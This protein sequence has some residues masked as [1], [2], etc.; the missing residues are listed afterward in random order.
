MAGLFISIWLLGAVISRDVVAWRQDSEVAELEVMGLIHDADLDHVTLPGGPAQP[1]EDAEPE[2]PS[3]F[4]HDPHPHP[5]VTAPGGPSQPEDAHPSEGPAATVDPTRRQYLADFL[6]GECAGGPQ[7]LRTTCQTLKPYAYER[8]RDSILGLFESLNETCTGAGCER[9]DFA[10]CVLRLVGHDLM[11]FNPDTKEGGSDACIDFEDMDNKGL[12]EC[13]TGLGEFG[14]GATVQGAYA[15]FCHELSLADF[16]VAAGEA[17]M[18]LRRPDWDATLKKSPT[19]EFDFKFGRETARSCD[20]GALPNP[21]DSCSAVEASFVK[22]LGLSWR[23]S[24]A[25][26]GVHTLG[27]AAAHNSGFDGWWTS[28]VDGARFDHVYYVNLLGAG[29]V[30]AK[31]QESGK[32]QWVRSDGGPATDMMLNTDLCMLWNTNGG[33]RAES[34]ADHDCCLWASEFGLDGAPSVCEG[35]DTFA[36]CCRGNATKRCGNIHVQPVGSPPAGEESARAIIDFAKDESL[37]LSVFKDAWRRV[38]Y[39]NGRHDLFSSSCADHPH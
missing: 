37:W 34:A 18:T 13:L 32:S 9:G 8:I 27:R 39:E 31:V 5:D 12:K 35:G 6:G 17:V 15:N 22:N 20:P 7:V 25:L 3:S 4:L 14:K 29:W 33:S 28:G 36:H 10:G 26:M 30:P 1:E 11:D 19:L 38:T 24:A 16:L 21:A 2:G 23:E